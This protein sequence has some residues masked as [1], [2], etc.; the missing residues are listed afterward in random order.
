MPWTYRLIRR[1]SENSSLFTSKH[2]SYFVNSALLLNI[3]QE[4]VLAK[5]KSAKGAAFDSPSHVN[6][7]RCYPGTREGILEHIQDWSTK[8]DGQ[9]IFWLN[10]GAGTGKST[11]SRT[12][13][14]SFA[15]KGMLG[16]S[17]FFK[18]GEADRGSMALFFPTIASQ[19]VQTFPQI[20]PHIRA[21]I[22][23]D[24][25]IYDRSIKEQFDKLI[26]EPIKKLS[27]VSQLPTIVIVADALDEC[28]NV[29]HVRLVV[30]LLSQVKH[31]A[32]ACLKFFVTSRP[33]LAIRLGFAD[34]CGH[35]EDLILHQVPS[36]IVERDIAL[37]LQHEF[38]VILQDYNKSV[39]SNRRLPLSWP[40]TESFQQLVSMSAPLFIFAATACRFVRDRRLGGPKEQLMKILEQQTIYGLISKL[41]ATYLPTV[42]GLVAGLSE[43]EKR[44]V[45]E[46]FKHIVGSIVTLASPLCIPSLTRLLDIPLEVI[47]D[48]LDL[49][50]S[51]LYVPP[52][53]QSPVRL[54]HLS[55]R[56]F[57]VDP[58]KANLEERYPFW[59]D[60]KKAHKKLAMQC[61]ELLVAKGTLKRNICCLKL[62]STLRSEINRRAIDAALPSEVQYACLYW[63]T[64]WKESKCS[65]EDGGII[66]HFL[67]NHLLHWLEALGIIGRMSECIGMINDLLSLVDV[68]Y[69]PRLARYQ[70]HD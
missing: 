26:T 70:V 32:S 15:N 67:N 58:E 6:S 16:A 45:C 30:H 14:Q 21:A 33:E 44:H 8:Q 5:L 37:L 25:T 20:A 69:P 48:Q 22:E 1:S 65:V 7:S 2:C 23:A 51:V 9:C 3:H 68:G 59:V 41:N 27:E 53:P 12:I 36:I 55:F 19:L 50:H 64:H 47:E 38:N 62:P 11:I 29:E 18:Y 40:G 17:F 42:N 49:L 54:L 13:A 43:A 31:S 39:S 4:A 61:L 57:L 56:D 24:L 35:Y 52:D 60:E 34:I 63:V 46:R 10:G 66:D 28:D